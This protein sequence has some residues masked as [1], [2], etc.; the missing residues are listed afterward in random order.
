M[1]DGRGLDVADRKHETPVHGTN[2]PL[3]RMMGHNRKCCLKNLSY[4]SDSHLDSNSYRFRAHVHA[5]L[6]LIISAN[7]GLREAPPTKKPSTSC[8]P[9]GKDAL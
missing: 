4:S 8:C 1:D 9:A 6:A 5:F 2:G 3:I 7:S